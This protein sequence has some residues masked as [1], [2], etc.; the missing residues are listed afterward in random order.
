MT[1][2]ADFLGLR[3]V[4]TVEPKP[5]IPPAPAHLEALAKQ[6]KD[7]KVTLILREV[8]YSDKTAL[9]LANA[10][11]ARVATVATMGGA[12]P[13]SQTYIGMI[14]A[15]LKAIREALRALDKGR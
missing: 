2:L 12:F 6:M 11:G 13:D 15:N 5:G 14:E 3:I 4:G 7:E 10:T 1:Y 8:Q 9:W